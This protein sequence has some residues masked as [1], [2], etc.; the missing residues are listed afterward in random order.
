MLLLRR[1]AGSYRTMRGWAIALLRDNEVISEC[2]EHG[3]ILDCGDSHAFNRALEIA[4]G[5]S[6]PGA[7]QA[8]VKAEIEDII[9]HVGDRCPECK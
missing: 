2:E 6:F 3:H 4:M 8:E 9:R 7:S 5:E 1:K